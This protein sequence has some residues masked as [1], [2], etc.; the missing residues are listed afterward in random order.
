MCASARAGDGPSGPKWAKRVVSTKT[1]TSLKLRVDLSSVGAI[2]M[3]TDPASVP[4]AGGACHLMSTAAYSNG[5]VCKPAW[6]IS[7]V[8]GLYC[9]LEKDAR[10]PKE[11]AL[12][13]YSPKVF[14]R[15]R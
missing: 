9:F 7:P 10:T 4:E 3:I 11:W 14:P 8:V 2:R 1:L 15:M 6:K 12:N 5:G 13:Q